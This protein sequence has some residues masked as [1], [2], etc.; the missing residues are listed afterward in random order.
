MDGRDLAVFPAPT[1]DELKAANMATLDAVVAS[2]EAVALVDAL[3]D[4]LSLRRADNGTRKLTEA[5]Y[6]SYR[7]AVGA[8]LADLLLNVKADQLPNPVYRSMRSNAFTGGPVTYRAFNEVQAALVDLGLLERFRG[9]NQVTPALNYETGEMG[10]MTRGKAARFRGTPAL[11][12][13]CHDHKV[14]PDQLNHHFHRPPPV[15][16]VTLKAGSTWHWGRKITGDRMVCPPGPQLETITDQIRDI[17]RFLS[18][19]RIDGGH[20]VG[21]QRMFS[22]G[23]ASDFAWNKGGRLYSAGPN[24]YQTEKKERRIEMRLNGVGVVEI[25][26]E[27]SFLTILHG[28]TQTPWPLSDNADPYAIDDVPRNIAKSWLTSSIGS[29]VA[30]KKWPKRTI[31]GYLKKTGRTLKDDYPVAN[32]GAAMIQRIPLLG[33]LDA[34]GMDWA[35]LMFE[36]SEIMIATMR[37]LMNMGVP[38]LPVHDSI[39]VPG[40]LEL[41][42][43]AAL[44][45]CFEDRTGIRPSLKVLRPTGTG[46]YPGSMCWTPDDEATS[47]THDVYDPDDDL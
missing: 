11:Y 43:V 15:D 5:A 17:N 12:R 39:L 46:R 35:D 3:M 16:L 20:H 8:L 26:I 44:Q 41:E 1:E 23:D 38:S 2:P 42:A 37:R 19:I 21:F 32:V 24:N 34:I 10:Q 40:H 28:L 6:S 22:M 33:R 14:H 7:L 13:L 27:A 18:D 30:I 45:A 47:L 29:G 25:D 36:E 4:R 31:E 9:Y